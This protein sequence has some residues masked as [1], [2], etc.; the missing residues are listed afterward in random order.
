M[1]TGDLKNNLR[2]LHSELKLVNYSGELDIEGLA[3]GKPTAFLPILHFVLTEFSLD[4][5]QYFSSKGYELLGKNDFKF[6]Q[7]I[8]RILRDEFSA[9]APLTKDQFF[10]LGFTERKLQ[11]VTSVLQLCRTKNEALKPKRRKTSRNKLHVTQGETCN[12]DETAAATTISKQVTISKKFPQ[13]SKQSQKNT[14]A[15][16]F[17][18]ANGIMENAI[19]QNVSMAANS[20][21]CKR[22]CADKRPKQST[23][24][25]TSELSKT[26][27]LPGSTQNS[28]IIDK[29]ECSPT[30]LNFPVVIADKTI[31]PKANFK[32]SNSLDRKPS[33]GINLMFSHIPLTQ[34]KVDQEFHSGNHDRPI[35]PRDIDFN[36]T[37]QSGE[38]SLIPDSQ[39]LIHCL[40]RQHDSSVII[41]HLRTQQKHIEK[42]E[43]DATE[44]AILVQGLARQ[45]SELS[46]RV[47]I[48]ETAVKLLEEK[49]N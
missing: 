15:I 2:K 17:S 41:N 20:G 5:A 39:H 43:K 48:L 19:S 3:I 46:A 44:R 27:P 1:T 13:S 24:K 8:Y 6:V 33:D 34:T 10:T 30:D 40:E 21:N 35:H 29:Y 36:K 22:L 9:K 31:L 4:L 16:E 23:D 45:N 49:I 38:T 26:H 14:H 42:L 7:V 11:F 28:G 47:M 18:S 25:S 12:N 32:N 37:T